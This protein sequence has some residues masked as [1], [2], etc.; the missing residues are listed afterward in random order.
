MKQLVEELNEKD[1]QGKE[2]LAL[3]AANSFA[4]T[5][6]GLRKEDFM[7]FLAEEYKILYGLT[8][9][10][11]FLEEEDKDKEDKEDNKD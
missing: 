2:Q 5:Y 1:L 10:G 8:G 11:D 7:K 9:G 4:K 6:Q 3:E